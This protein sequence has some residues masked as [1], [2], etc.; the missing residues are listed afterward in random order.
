MFLV[1]GVLYRH[2]VQGMSVGDDLITQGH[3][4]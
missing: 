3:F 2:P 1:C 4:Y